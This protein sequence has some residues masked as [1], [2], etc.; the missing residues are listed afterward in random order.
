M[1]GIQYVGIQYVVPGGGNAARSSVPA[2]TV[3]WME[4]PGG[5]QFM[6]SLESD[7]TKAT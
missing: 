2:W 3:P 6:G 5:L 4:E 7:S 1:L